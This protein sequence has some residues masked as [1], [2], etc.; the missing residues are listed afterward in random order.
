MY[1]QRGWGGTGVRGQEV[2]PPFGQTQLYNTTKQTNCAPSLPAPTSPTPPPITFSI[3]NPKGGNRGF[4]WF[5]QWFWRGFGL[6]SKLKYWFYNGFGW[7]WVVL[8][9]FWLVLLWFCNGFGWF[10]NGFAMVLAGFALVLQWFWLVMVWFC[11]GFVM[12][13]ACSLELKS[14]SS[15][16]QF[17]DPKNGS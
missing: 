8:Q 10:C 15:A 6:F 12:A 9:W 13:L 1:G 16:V 7:F 3:I 11:Y 4:D 2:C 17:L 14:A 5:L